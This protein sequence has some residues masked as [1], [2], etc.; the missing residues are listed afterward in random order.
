MA[1]LAEHVQ[2]AASSLESDG[3][4]LGE[5]TGKLAKISQSQNEE[6]TQITNL[7]GTYETSLSEISSGADM[8]TNAVKKVDKN[9]HE[10]AQA[11][12]RMRQGMGQLV[13]QIQQ[14]TETVTELNSRS[15]SISGVLDVIRNIAGQTNLLALNAAIEAA[16]AGE[17][18]RGFA[19]VADEVRTLAQRTQDSTQEIDAMIEALQQGSVS[20]VNVIKSS[21]QQVN[22]CMKEVEE[23]ERLMEYVSDGI[24]ALAQTNE[25]I[26]LQATSQKS[27]QKELSGRVGSILKSANSTVSES[28]EAAAAGARVQSLA[29]NL[30][31]CLLYTSPSPRDS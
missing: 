31:N 29:D 3:H 17:Q 6:I 20:S 11:S 19:V 28:Q 8:A 25:S 1:D 15:D 13:E 14:A 5:S 22:E 23:T 2:S 26:S 18:G 9:A 24:K 10:S 16:R 27:A 12:L 30:V 21:Q 7:I 4:A